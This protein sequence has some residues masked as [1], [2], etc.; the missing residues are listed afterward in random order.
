MLYSMCQESNDKPTMPQLEHAIK[1]NFG[2][3]E[4]EDLNPF[5]EFMR[6]I[7]KDKHRDFK[8]DDV[9]IKVCVKPISFDILSYRFKVCTCQV[10]HQASVSLSAKFQS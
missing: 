3:L 8:I 6:V 2:G 4:T 5:E 9:P 10:K 1:R 7:P